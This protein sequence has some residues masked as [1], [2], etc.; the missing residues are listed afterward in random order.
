VN[1]TINDLKNLNF[2]AAAKSVYR[3]AVKSA[4][5]SYA[6]ATT[7]NEGVQEVATAIDKRV[8]L[9]GRLAAT[10]IAISQATA[11]IAGLVPHPGF[12][13]A[14]AAISVTGSMAFGAKLSES[15]RDI[16][17]D[18]KSTNRAATEEITTILAEKSGLP[19]RFL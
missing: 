9:E 14:A 5:A 12:K 4:D 10:G 3:G 13:I 17:G 8:K 15:I 7:T 18:E 1:E 2:G 11:T 19:K 6:A 16:G